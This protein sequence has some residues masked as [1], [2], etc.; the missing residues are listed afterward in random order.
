LYSHGS[1]IVGTMQQVAGAAGTALLV[2]IM[3]SHIV[4][5]SSGVGSPSSTAIGVHYAFL[6]A[7]VIS[8]LAIPVAFLVRP[9]AVE[10]G[11]TPAHAGH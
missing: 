2:T 10:P 9:P 1:A 7:A 11:T 5:D 8:V 6:A 3:S 4:F